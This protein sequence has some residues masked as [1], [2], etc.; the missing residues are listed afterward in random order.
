MRWTDMGFERDV[1]WHIGRSF[2]DNRLEM[3]CPC[4]LEPCGLVSRDRADPNCLQHTDV[5]KTIRQVHSPEDC[6]GVL[7]KNNQPKKE[8]E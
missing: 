8:Q 2:T 3:V 7:I 1:P 5:C 4:P 6:P